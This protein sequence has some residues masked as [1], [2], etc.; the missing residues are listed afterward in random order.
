M[1]IWRGVFNKLGLNRNKIQRSPIRIFLL[2]DDMRRHLWFTKRFP[3][4]TL[5]IAEEVAR[6]L[7]LLQENVYDAIFL[8]HDLL[9]K[10]YKHQS[11]RDD[12]NTGFAVARFLAERPEL[13]RASTII[14]HTRNS[15]GAMR[16]V[17]ELRNAGRQAEYVPYPMLEH[18]IRHYWN[19]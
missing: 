4:D 5:H 19:R 18:K 10:H 2:D 12:K 14:V 11:A 15:D 6:G 9:P 3:D 16:M 13:Q 7:E 8:D 1:S 17:D